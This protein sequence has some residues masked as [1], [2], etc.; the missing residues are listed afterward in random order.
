L[1]PQVLERDYGLCEQVD[2]RTRAGLIPPAEDLHAAVAPPPGAS[3]GIRKQPG[4]GRRHR[5]IA[6]RQK[7][8]DDAGS[9]FWRQINGQINV[10]CESVHAMQY[11]RQTTDNNVAKLT[12]FQG[13]EQSVKIRWH[14]RAFTARRRW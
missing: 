10:G 14:D 7:R 13:S 3:D 11:E 8:I 1:P 5:A 12:G 2:C 4:I 9:G 6:G